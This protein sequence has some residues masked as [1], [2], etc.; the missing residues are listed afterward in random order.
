MLLEAIFYE[1]IMIM[2][3]PF[4]AGLIVL[5]FFLG[6]GIV[7]RLNSDAF[8][9]EMIGAFF[10]VFAFIPELRLIVGVGLGILVGMGLLAIVRR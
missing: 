6:L 3:G 5:L 4:I 9:A 1:Q 8:I 7:L 2:L 10:L